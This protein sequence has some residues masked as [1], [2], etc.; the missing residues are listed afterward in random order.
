MR[1]C[2]PSDLAYIESL[3]DE[4]YGEF[5]DYYPESAAGELEPTDPYYGRNVIWDGYDGR[6]IRVHPDNIR[7]MP[8][9][10][11]DADKLAAIVSGIDEAHDRVVF[12]A[13]YGMVSV[14][15]PQDVKESIEYEDEEPFTTGDPELD[16]WLVDPSIFDED[17][18]EELQKSLVKAMERGDGDLGQI[19]ATV[20]DGNH[21]AFGALI[22]GEPYIYMILAEQQMNYLDPKDPRDEIIRELLE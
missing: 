22:A 16:A 8:E 4:G 7:M 2:N 1:H 10:I 21:R 12:T 18:Q 17:E 15:T 19:I 3:A 6:M 13:P 9:N 5:A 11:F 14:I 20:R